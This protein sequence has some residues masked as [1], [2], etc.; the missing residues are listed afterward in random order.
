MLLPRTKTTTAAALAVAILVPKV[1]VATI[2]KKA[3]Q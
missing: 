1:Q 3:L 2:A